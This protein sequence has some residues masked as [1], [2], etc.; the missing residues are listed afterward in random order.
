VTKK[1]NEATRTAEDTTVAEI[2]ETVAPPRQDTTGVHLVAVGQ[3]YLLVIQGPEALHLSR[4]VLDFVDAL[5]ERAD[6]KSSK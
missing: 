5:H 3:S 4:L 6:A 1:K 2:L